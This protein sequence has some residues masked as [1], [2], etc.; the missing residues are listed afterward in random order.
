[1]DCTTLIIIIALIAFPC[2]LFFFVWWML[3]IIHD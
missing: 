2:G 3:R 1:M